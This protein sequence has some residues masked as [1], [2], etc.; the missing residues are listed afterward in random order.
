M[1][2][3]LETKILLVGSV[4]WRANKPYLEIPAKK[5]KRHMNKVLTQ[6]TPAKVISLLGVA[7]FSLSFLFAVSVTDASFSG[8]RAPVYNPFSAENV[9]AVIDQT[10]AS[11]SQFMDTNFIQPLMA[12]YKVYGENLVFAF[13]ESGLA[14]ALGV[15][16][17]MDNP[18]VLQGQV[19]GAYIA[20]PEYRQ[21]GMSSVYSM[22]LSR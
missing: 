18:Q 22:I 10:A 4:N 5:T 21:E 14:Y 16:S 20:S 1:P 11:Y 12:D 19:A 7:I 6:E 2:N 8:T 17:L 13:K 9:M 15:E 3:I